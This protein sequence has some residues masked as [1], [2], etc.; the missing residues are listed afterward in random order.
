MKGVPFIAAFPCRG[1]SFGDLGFRLGILDWK[2]RAC[3]TGRM[4]GKAQFSLRWIFFAIAMA[5]LLAAEGAVFAPEVALAVGV[6]VSLLSC[7]ALVAGIVYARDVTRA[8]CIGALAILLV[9][10]LKLVSSELPGM[11]DPGDMSLTDALFPMT[12]WWFHIPNANSYGIEFSLL[13]MF[14]IAGGAFGALVRWLA[15]ERRE[16]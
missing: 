16:A 5:A 11:R 10:R 6:S 2:A 7:A 14:A 13:W 3:Y 1:A 15:H 9:T 8:F 4:A 12:Q